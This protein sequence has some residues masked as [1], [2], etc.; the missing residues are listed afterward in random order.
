MIILT[1]DEILEHIAKIRKEIKEGAVFVYP[2]DTIYGIGCNAMDSKAVK[3]IR[4]VKNRPDQPFSVIA[5]SKQWIL[6]NCILHK[7]N[8]HWLDKL[9]GSY[10]LVLKMKSKSSVSSYVNPGLDTVG[11]RIPDHWFTK[12]INEVGV[13]VVTTSVNKTGEQ[14]MTSLDDLDSAIRKG[15]DYIFYEGIKTGKPSTVVILDKDEAVIK[16]R[17]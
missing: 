17:K 6:N 4:A 7:N 3:R 15:V 10:T 11:V 5:P 13:P 1:K 2:T 16:E 12:I 8:M 14:Y 9:P